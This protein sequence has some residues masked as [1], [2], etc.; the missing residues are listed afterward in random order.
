MPL[1]PLSI[2]IVKINASENSLQQEY[3]DVQLRGI[4][5]GLV[6]SNIKYAKRKKM[7]LNNYLH[8]YIY[9]YIYIFIFFV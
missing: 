8:I 6:I 2:D 9:I 4:T 7:L 1:D 5:K 3:K